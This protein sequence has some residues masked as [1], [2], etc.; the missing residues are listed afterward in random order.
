MN[1]LGLPLYELNGQ[2]VGFIAYRIGLAK[3]RGRAMEERW[4]SP[5]S[6]R[7]QNGKARRKRLREKPDWIFL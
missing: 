5:R 6:S 2:L 1:A 3:K 4:N 7:V